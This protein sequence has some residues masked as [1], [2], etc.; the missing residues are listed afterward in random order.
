MSTPTWQ[1]LGSY[2]ASPELSD[3]LRTAV[4]PGLRFRQFC[5]IK[6]PS[7]QD[8]HK[9]AIYHW[10][11]YSDV[12][13][14]G[15]AL[16]ETDVIPEAGYTIAQG[17]LTITEY[18]LAVPYT[19]K[20]DDLSFHPVKEIIH[21]ALKNDCKKALD[22]AAHDQFKATVLRVVPTSGTNTSAVDLTTNGTATETNNIAM[23]ADHIKTIIDTMK[24]RNIPP[25]EHEDYYAIARPSSF[26]AFKDDLESKKIYIETGF[27]D[28]RRGEIGRYEG[29]RFVEQT[30]ISAGTGSTAAAA[31]TNSLS[32]WCFFLGEDTVAEAVAVPEEIRG[33]LAVDYGR[34][35]G[36]AW[37][38]LLGFGLTHTAAAQ[39]RIIMWDSAK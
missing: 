5:D 6:D 37:Y 2:F 11:V 4:Q 22:S 21:K 23:G 26:R 12:D 16:T 15:A 28:I 30:N 32:D 35:R 18:G 24:E 13:T 7:Q 29:C 10:N 36:I 27:A 3:I 38:A 1:N 31:W 34:D 33:K 14:A 20:F 8:R 17:T 25:Y 19:G 9:G 39:T